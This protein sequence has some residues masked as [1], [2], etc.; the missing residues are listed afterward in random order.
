M[1]FAGQARS[2]SSDD[3]F[4]LDANGTANH[5]LRDATDRVVER[6]VQKAGRPD[7]VTR[8]VYAGVGD[9]AWGVLDGSNALTEVTIALPGGATVRVTAA[10]APMGWSYMGQ[11]CQSNSLQSSRQRLQIPSR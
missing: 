5:Y 6:R 2:F 1:S 4:K 9:S 3:G 7:Q 11:S 10:G 8:F